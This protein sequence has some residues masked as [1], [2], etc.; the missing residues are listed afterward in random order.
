M[1]R[2]SAPSVLAAWF[3]LAAL[4]LFSS[5]LPAANESELAER[6]AM[7]R[8]DLLLRGDA[9]SLAALA[10][11]QEEKPEYSGANLS[12]MH[13]A[14]AAAPQRAEIL[15]LELTACMRVMTCDPAA[16][17]NRLHALDPDNGAAFA[18]SLERSA[19]L[20]DLDGRALTA[21]A[22]SRR[23]T[24]YWNT[25]V[26][27]VAK[28]ILATHTMTA[29]DA[30]TA[31]VGAL[32][33]Q[34]LPL[35][36]MTKVCAPGALEQPDLRATCRR[37]A[38]V[39]RNSDTYIVELVGIGIA[40]PLYAP[41][42]PERQGLEEEDRVARYRF[43]TLSTMLATGDADAREHYFALFA[44]FATEQEMTRAY[45]ERAGLPIDPPA[46]WGVAR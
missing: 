31:A 11:L 46:D 8:D 44:S 18:G 21:I 15:W 9:D 3:A 40:R 23:F 42:T 14:A 19:Q 4:S 34:P 22:N 26:A 39:L 13:D 36:P 28:A 25:L 41:G 27:H 20:D 2:V 45:L 6:A 30:Y 17:E 35:T 32:A 7:R 12:L 1:R 29:S 43:R 33:A 16:I 5:A 10:L 37:L 38:S 24:T